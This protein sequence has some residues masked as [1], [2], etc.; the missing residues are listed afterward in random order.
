[1]NIAGELLNPR[2]VFATIGLL[3]VLLLALA[4]LAGKQKGA[5]IG[6]QDGYFHRERAEQARRD[7]TGRFKAKGGAQ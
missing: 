7:A 2:D 6:W 5:A 1:M 4:Y 3:V